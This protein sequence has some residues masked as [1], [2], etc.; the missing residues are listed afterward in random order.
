MAL[1]FAFGVMNF[2]WIAGLMVF[3]LIEKVLPYAG[4][5]SRVAGL[6]AIGAGIAMMAALPQI[7]SN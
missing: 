1:L 6:V 5:V 2:Y 7:F 4:I 3:V